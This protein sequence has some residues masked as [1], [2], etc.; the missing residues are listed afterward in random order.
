MAG[1]SNTFGAGKLVALLAVA[2][3][4][5]VFSVS[6][7]RAEANLTQSV[8][9]PLPVA[10]HLIVYE[11]SAEI[12]ES[13]PGLIVA[14]RES[15]LGFQQG[16][17]IDMIGVDV[18]DQVEA[19]AELAQ[20]DTRTLRAQIAAA[21]A[22]T[23]E[24]AAQ[25]A[26]A[27]DTQE[28]QAALLERGHISQQRYDEAVASTTAAIARG[29]AARASADALRVQLDL[30]DIEA[31]F[32]GVI[33]ARMAD[34]GTIA[35]PGQPIL[36][37]VENGMLEIRVGL[38]AAVASSLNTGEIYDFDDGEGGFTAR[39][40]AATGVIDRQTRTITAV[41]DIDAESDVLAG[42]VGRLI[43]A[44]PIGVRGFWVP[45]SALAESRRGLWS[46]YLLQ[47]EDGAF[48]LEPRVVE[49]VRVEAD[50]AFVRGAVEDGSQILA[51]GLQR[52]IPGQRVSISRA[53][54]RVG[55]SE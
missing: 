49:T 8:P 4:V 41:F 2:L 25:T 24:A 12:D 36:Q 46:V 16:G 18:G 37:L 20:L 50:R 23:A 45:T 27:R 1:K 43:I 44:T 31:P 38:P 26:L 32:A 3:A 48:R 53:A 52:V 39:F 15:A 42:D 13:Y 7:W 40:R 55:A 29:N 22:Q 14:R 9:Q 51:S 6:A 21:D 30:M 11:D 33:T 17:L 19:G 47:P 54:G 35:A 28:R 10:A 34:E 5:S